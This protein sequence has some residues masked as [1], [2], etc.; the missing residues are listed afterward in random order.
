MAAARAL[1]QEAATKGDTVALHLIYD[2]ARRAKY[3]NKL[4]GEKQKRSE[5]QARS[6]LTERVYAIFEQ[7]GGPISHTEVNKALKD[8]GYDAVRQA[9]TLA[10]ARWR[11]E[12]N[13]AR[14]M[15]LQVLDAVRSLWEQSGTL[16]APKTLEKLKV[17]MPGVT[18]EQVRRATARLR[19]P[20]A[21]LASYGQEKPTWDDEQRRYVYPAAG[22]PVPGDT[23]LLPFHTKYEQKEEQT[24]QLTMTEPAKRG[25]N[26]KDR[27]SVV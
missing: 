21:A 1:R 14:P 15:P 9:I 3:H 10:R 6:A 23:W 8:A 17:S 18:F 7:R 5:G 19:D 12:H 2:D 16:S 26:P 27:K 13:D 25:P 4:V 20:Q 22:V 11:E 24:W